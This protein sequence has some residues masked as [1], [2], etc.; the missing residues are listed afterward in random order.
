MAFTDAAPPRP[1]GFPSRA[2]AALSALTAAL[3]ALFVVGPAALASTAPGGGYGDQRHLVAAFRSAFLDYWRSG[4]R[5]YN[6][7][8]ARVVHYWLLYHLAKGAV[9]LF[10][11]IV[12]GVLAVLLGKACLAAD[13]HE[14]GKRLALVTAGTVTV[15]LALLSLLALMANI[16]GA[17]APFSSLMPMLW[18]GPRDPAL[19]GPLSQ[20]GQQLADHRST[21]A[22]LSP[23]VTAMLDDDI[24]YH[25]AMVV[26]AG[27]VAA[28]FIAAGVLVWR[29]FRRT[30]RSDRRTR[31]FLATSGVLAALLALAA[32]VVV[33]AN[34]STVAD[35]V[36]PLQSAVAGGW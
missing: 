28:L 25:G 29:R 9:S 7:G 34:V 23:A 16:Q 20:I 19:T 5:V 6:P 33:A 31:R 14:A 1:T 24:T 30:D 13:G 4:D 17:I 32:L 18:E 35:P 26:I 8:L 3:I 22:R 2:I 36:P 10:L 27:V 15:L 12:L 11:L 21:G